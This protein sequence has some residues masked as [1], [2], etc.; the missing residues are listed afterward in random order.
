MTTAID[1]SILPLMG[2]CC[3]QV[4]VQHKSAKNLKVVLP[5]HRLGMHFQNV[6]CFQSA[7]FITPHLWQIRLAIIT[8]LV[9]E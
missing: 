1:S 8:S 9:V 6:I 7:G 2:M 3:F 4:G 5:H